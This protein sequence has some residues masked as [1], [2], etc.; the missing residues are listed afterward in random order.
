MQSSVHMAPVGSKQSNGGIGSNPHAQIP[1][2]ML[3]L[4]LHTYGMD[5]TPQGII[6]WI[7]NPLYQIVKWKFR[8]DPFNNFDIQPTEPVAAGSTVL[9]RV[10]SPWTVSNHKSAPFDQDF[11]LIL[12][13]AVGR[14]YFSQTPDMPYPVSA[15]FWNAQRGVWMDGYEMNSTW[16]KSSALVIDSIKMSALDNVEYWENLAS[17]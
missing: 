13:V 1:F 11:Y 9:K 12:N 14:G 16:G 5:W 4:E 15:D 6:C 10:Y 17:A 3:P 7:D 2:S 8:K